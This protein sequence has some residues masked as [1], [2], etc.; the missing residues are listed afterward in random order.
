[1]GLASGQDG[2]FLRGEE[3]EWMEKAD[4]KNDQ[5]LNLH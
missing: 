4:H 1:M 2:Y 5:L 3:R